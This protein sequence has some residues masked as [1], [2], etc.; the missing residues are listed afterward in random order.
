[1]E[2]KEEISRL[3][4]WVL[5]VVSQLQFPC[6]SESFITQEM[7]QFQLY[8]WSNMS[9]IKHSLTN[10]KQ[11]QIASRQ[12]TKLKL[13]MLVTTVRSIHGNNQVMS[14]SKRINGFLYTN[15]LKWWRLSIMI[16]KRWNIKSQVLKQLLCKILLTVSEVGFKKFNFCRWTMQKWSK[17]K[18]MLLLLQKLWD[19]SLNNMNCYL[20][21]ISLEK[22]QL[23][24]RNH[25]RAG[26]WAWLWKILVPE[27]NGI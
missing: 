10:S 27:S 3:S 12:L 15:N 25:L 9:V 1:M 4:V 23:K 20:T 17:F 16:R 22:N 18:L 19:N 6:N 8:I 24:V 2:V 13:L 14:D 5:R 7:K 26:Q 21:C 11:C